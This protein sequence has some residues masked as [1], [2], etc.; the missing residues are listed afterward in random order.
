[1]G[2]FKEYNKYTGAGTHI[3]YTQEVTTCVPTDRPMTIS[4]LLGDLLRSY[5]ACFYRIVKAFRNI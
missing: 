5:I 2:S 3:E 1:L 4:G